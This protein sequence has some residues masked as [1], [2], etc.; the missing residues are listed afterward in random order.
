MVEL[1]TQG[2]TLL[3]AASILHLGHTKGC[4][5]HGLLTGG[6]FLSYPLLWEEMSRF[7]FRAHSSCDL[8]PTDC[9]GSALPSHNEPGDTC[10]QVCY[11]EGHLLYP[12][13]ELDIQNEMVLRKFACLA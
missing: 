13:T 11:L 8:L 1:P 2:R 4:G 7:D 9:M 10:C 12:Y 6:P 3:S 5:L